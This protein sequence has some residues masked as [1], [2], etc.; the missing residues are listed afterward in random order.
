MT[1]RRSQRTPLSDVIEHLG[2]APRT[3]AALRD[4]GLFEE[5]RLDPDSAEELR[6][7]HVLIEQL[8]VN[9]AGVHVT[10]Q[11]RRRMIA[12]E[13]RVARLARIVETLCESDRR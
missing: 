2:L 11:M 9:A 5:E 7:A 1:R 8:G 10:L 13:F 12:L 4:E 6:L 3:L